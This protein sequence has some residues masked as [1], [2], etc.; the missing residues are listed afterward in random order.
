M[1]RRPYQRRANQYLKGLRE[2]WLLRRQG[3]KSGRGT[4]VV[5]DCWRPSNEAS[6]AD[7]IEFHQE[8][9]RSRKNRNFT[10]KLEQE[11]ENMRQF[12][13]L[14]QA[15]MNYSHM[16]KGKPRTRAPEYN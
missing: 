16:P 9:M 10:T 5:N 13:V 7:L 4:G 3:H 14:K 12:G 8:N 6:K 11:V 1:S 2:H 15:L